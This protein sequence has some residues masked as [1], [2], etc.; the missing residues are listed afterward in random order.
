MTTPTTG[1]N[2]AIDLLKLGLALMVVGIHANP[3]V[4]LGRT[5]ILL[6]GDGLFRL[7]VPVFLIF[8]GY[9]LHAAVEAGRPWLYVKRAVQLY[10]I[11]MLLYLP[12]YWGMFSGQSMVERIKMLV[13]GFW[14]LWYLSGMAM[15]AALV[16]LIRHWSARA[17]WG[18][19]AITFLCGIAVTYAIA[20]D[21]I[22]VNKAVFGDTLKPNRNAL[23][24]CLPF[25]L[26]GYLIRR[27]ALADHISLRLALTFAAL[28]SVLILTESLFLHHVAPRGVA[29]DTMLS[30]GLA[31]PMLALAALKWPGIAQSRAAGDY[32]SG[33]YFIH[34]AICAMLFRHTEL[35]RPA[36]YALTV[37]GAVA[38]TWMIRRA[39][40]TRKLL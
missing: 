3:F 5:A 2:R 25:L 4:P 9:F 34:V 22:T 19:M 40:L 7:G 33:I 18:L 20:W 10:A 16:T 15:A 14:H 35:Q 38:G 30:L 1:R 24:L 37:A 28:G 29:H 13:F 39:G 8:N 21:L 6:T 36:V 17:M 31:A 26:A 23:F 12:V 11:W 27:N 32:A